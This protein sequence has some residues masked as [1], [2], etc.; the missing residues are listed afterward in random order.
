MITVGI[1]A[2]LGR[3]NDFCRAKL[4][5]AAGMCVARSHY[6]ITVEHVIWQMMDDTHSDFSLILAHYGISV[7]GLREQLNRSLEDFPT[8]NS[9]KPVFSPRLIEWYQEAQLSGS[10]ELGETK[11]RSGVLLLACLN[12]TS[13][14]APQAMIELLQ[15]INREDLL[16]QFR[17]LIK[18]SCEETGTPKE[19]R[20]AQTGEKTSLEKYCEDFTRKAR[21]GHIDP[22]F[23]RD[24]EIRQVVDI[25]ARRRKNNP[26]VV[27]EAGVGKTA[28]VEGLALRIVEGDV[29]DFLKNVRLMSLDMGLLQAGAGVKGEFENRLKKVIEEVKASEIPIIM[30]IDEAHTMIGA[31]AS[32]GGSDAANLLKPALARGELRTIAATTWSEYKKYFEKDA[33]LARRFQLVYLDEPSEESATLILRG[34]KKKYE[35]AHG[36]II[37]DDAVIAA[38]QMSSRYISGR[39]LPDKAIDL[40]DT[41]AARIKVLLTAKPAVVENIERR[42]QAFKREKEALERDG[43]Y[44][45]PV[46]KERN[47]QI[48]ND[49]TDLEKEHKTLHARWTLEKELA[50]K[51]ITLREELYL[52]QFPPLNGDVAQEVATIVQDNLGTAKETKKKKTG[53]EKGKTPQADAPEQKARITRLNDD[54]AQLTLELEKIQGKDPLVQIEVGPDVVSKVVSDWTGIP[55]GKMMHD[56]AQSIMDMEQSLKKRIK[57][58]DRALSEISRIIRAS[59]AGLKDPR[60]PLGVFLLT[61]P[62]G[63]GK[64]ETGLAMAELLFG[65]ERF[66][67]A[68]NMSEFQEKHTVSRL[69]GS[70]PGY[71]GYGEGGI[72]TEA[73]RQRPYSVVLLDEAEKANHDVMNLFYQVFDKGVLAD[74]EG[75]NIN[76]KNTIIFMTSNLASEQIA[77]CLASN[78]DISQEDLSATVRPILSGHFKPSLLARMTIVPYQ[79]LDAAIMQDIVRMKL[80]HV[81]DRMMTTH[82]VILDIDQSVS[83][84]IADRCL[85]VETG[86]RNIDHI[87]DGTILPLLSQEILSFL[88]QGDLPEKLDLSV[89]PEGHFTLAA[90]QKKATKKHTKKK[91]SPTPKKV[92]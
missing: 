84:Q 32:A 41:S 26:I 74:G 70:P 5:A 68:V 51:L 50:G 62:S 71:V 24:T 55:V 20:P 90:S 79:P 64:T 12:R 36:V 9:T 46:D 18:N 17:G 88:A 91:K 76:F 3:L 61:G 54:I 89:S 22:V 28:I 19:A 31:G 6:E 73:I 86:A 40:L 49:I 25:F 37:R 44:G 82:K 2:L 10:V 69:I 39:Y 65:G 27:G 80:K 58:Q 87:M 42:L 15:D 52:T 35:T 63:V 23:G 67:V 30:F 75:R 4:E 21:D 48:L 53:P 57:G 7:S 81:V 13:Q 34:L 59:K 66:T 85:E 8:G 60:Q 45:V 47:D 78:P 14:F 16:K 43:L 38:S 83:K 92:G 56:E 72:L 29:P 33:A 1:K 77:E 11:I